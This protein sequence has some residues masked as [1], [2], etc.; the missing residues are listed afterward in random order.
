MVAI[1]RNNSIMDKLVLLNDAPKVDIGTDYEI[2]KQIGGGSYGAVYEAVHKA[3]K[4]RV[5]IKQ[6][7]HIFDDPIDGKRVL[8]EVQLLRL[9][10]D[11]NSNVVRLYEILEPSNLSNFNS[12]CMVLEYAQGDLKKLIKAPISLHCIHI[13]KLLYN[14]LLGIKYIHSAGVLHRDI[15]PANIL[16]NEDCSVRICDFGL[17]RSI[18]GIESPSATLMT[19]AA[20]P[21]LAPLSEASPSPGV[22][23]MN[24]TSTPTPTSEG[25]AAG[26][27]G[28][29][30]EEKEKKRKKE[31]IQSL[32]GAWKGNRMLTGHVATR[33]YRA[34]ELILLEKDYGPEI[35]VWSVGCIFAEMLSM[36][37]EKDPRSEARLPLFPGLSCFPLSPAAKTESTVKGFPISEHDQMG[38]IVEVL[39]T[40]AEEDCS[41][42]SDPKAR[43]YIFAF[44]PKRPINLKERYPSASDEAIDLLNKMLAFNPY[45]RISI[46]ECLNHPF[47]APVRDPALEVTAQ[48]YASLPFEAAQCLDLQQL[49]DLFI[50]EIN[51]Y[52][53]LRQT[54]P[55][56]YV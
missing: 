12:L 32:K 31:T 28:K 23:P 5:A 22:E 30:E 41:F 27:E 33:W 54:L 10:R 2:V 40:P 53:H 52:K 24:T 34:P 4:T 35:D 7:G 50:E 21:A 39:G 8:R 42:I 37:C 48:K 47:I 56:P 9:L 51:H 20:P 6:A 18:V 13:Q 15:K 16:I 29:C 49:R 36:T 25:G 46:E 11:A 1:K 17:A 45:F 3:T 38:K 43:E 44:P 26:G 14:L 19:S 55:F